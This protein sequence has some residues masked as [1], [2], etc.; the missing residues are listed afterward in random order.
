M[1]DNTIR[2][3]VDGKLYVADPDDLELGEVEVIEEFND[4]PLAD[5]DFNRA[6]GLVSLVW[7]VMHREDSTVTV[8]DVRR[9]KF[10]TIT[11]AEAE[12]VPKRPTR[13]KKAA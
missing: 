1:P 5:I 2:L 6:R 13:A 12:E 4:A 9:I 8:D 10:S 7:L 3:M 11:D